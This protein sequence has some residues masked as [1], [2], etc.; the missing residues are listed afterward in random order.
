MPIAAYLEAEEA[1]RKAAII[2]KG[3]HY[4]PRM[5][6]TASILK[7]FKSVLALCL[8]RHL[9]LELQQKIKDLWDALARRN[10]RRLGAVDGPEV[11]SNIKK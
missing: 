3:K 11:L 5:Q 4:T 6:D 1:K 8:S 10:L 2:K 9:S 7:A